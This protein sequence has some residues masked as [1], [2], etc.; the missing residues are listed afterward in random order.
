MNITMLHDLD[1]GFLASTLKPAF[2]QLG[3]TCTVV[4]TL[5]TYLDPEPTHIDYLM[6]EMSDDAIH[7]LKS[8]IFKDTDLFIIRSITDFTLKASGVLPFITKD[9]TIYKVH[10]SELRERNVPYTLKTW[11]INWYNKEPVV[12]GP[13]DP[14]LFPLYRENTITHIERPCAFDTFPRRRRNKKQPF[15]LTTPTNIERKGTHYLLDN[16]KSPIMPLR[17]IHGV[18][19]QEALKWKS[20]ATFYIDNIGSYKHGPYGMNSVE[21]WYYKIPVYSNYNPM[22]EAIVPE[23]PELINWV[24]PQTVQTAIRPPFVYKKQLNNARK[25]ALHTHD[26]MRIAQ[27]YTK[28]I[29]Q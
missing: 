4:Q 13:R 10:G 12:C 1:T 26:P 19:R 29:E 18:S 14:S 2:E 16:W 27:Q 7:S 17:V 24:C 25:Y 9:N 21:A 23:L 20:R 8:Y 28:V 3:H 11:R 5:T 15:A 22:D 6:S